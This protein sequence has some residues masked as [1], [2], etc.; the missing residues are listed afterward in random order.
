MA[1]V[2]RMT[3]EEV[4]S[5]ADFAVWWDESC[6]RREGGALFVD[7]LRR[8]VAR[9]M[10][11]RNFRQLTLVSGDRH[12]GRQS[13]W[14]NAELVAVV[15]PYQEVQEKAPRWNKIL[16]RQLCLHSAAK[17]GDADELVKLLDEPVNPDTMREGSS[18]LDTAA[19]RGHVT[20]IRHL[21]EAGANVVGAL[22]SAAREGQ[23]CAVECLLQ[24]GADKDAANDQWLTPLH[25]AAMNCQCDIVTCLVEARA[26][27]NKTDRKGRTAKQLAYDQN[28]HHVMVL[29]P[30][31][32]RSVVFR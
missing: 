11:L 31:S 10:Q 28:H 22:H 32:R 7:E 25:V 5:E 8:E 12:L 17:T 6:E 16:S 4:L 3:G 20:I 26:D 15:R 9:R 29:F 30:S 23:L 24:L 14:T 27:P 2:R 18:A 19:A 1:C 21:I 13:A